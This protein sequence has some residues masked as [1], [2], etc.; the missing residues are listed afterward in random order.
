M[1]QRLR[2]VQ[3]Q[4]RRFLNERK[5]EELGAIRICAGDG[6]DLLGLLASEPESK[7]HARLL[8]LDQ[9]NVV[10]AR[11]RASAAGCRDVH[12]MWANASST[13]AYVGAAP[14]DLVLV[15][16]VFGNVPPEDIRR[17]IRTLPQLRASNAWVIWTRHREHPDLTPTIRSWFADEGFLERS[18]EVT[19]AESGPGAYPVQAVGVHMW[20]HDPHPLR[21]HQRMFTFFR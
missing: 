12:V 5:G 17:T 20:P 19:T 9:T 2:L 8:A 13:D 11:R 4:I 14:A 16:G 6:R 7:V 10:S 1:G 21:R 3:A 18:I 15:C